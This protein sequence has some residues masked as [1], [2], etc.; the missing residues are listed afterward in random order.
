ML[1]IKVNQHTAGRL[2]S[3]SFHIL[4][5]EDYKSMWCL[6]TLRPCHSQI[7]DLVVLSVDALRIRLRGS[8]E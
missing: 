3:D 8:H 7:R 2:V 6:S 1:E 4:L 5:R